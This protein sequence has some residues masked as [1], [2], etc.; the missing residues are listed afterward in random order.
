MS[1]S[2]RQPVLAVSSF[3]LCGASRT[4]RALSA[5]TAMVLQFDPES[6]VGEA[7]EALSA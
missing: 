2:L 1:P 4:S 5:L 6:H 7:L 3:A